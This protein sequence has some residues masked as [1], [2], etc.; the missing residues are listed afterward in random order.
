MP[1]FLYLIVFDILLKIR[2][3]IFIVSWLRKISSVEF[4]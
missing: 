1:S 3:I 4:F 2:L